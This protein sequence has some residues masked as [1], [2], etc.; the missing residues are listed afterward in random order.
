MY[1]AVVA[2]KDI[3]CVPHLYVR[4]ATGH[5]ERRTQYLHLAPSNL[6]TNTVLLLPEQIFATLLIHYRL[7]FCGFVKEK[8]SKYNPAATAKQYWRLAN[9]QPSVFVTNVVY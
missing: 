1:P 3:R 8:N 9:Q 7:N 4:I 2:L 6:C 5:M